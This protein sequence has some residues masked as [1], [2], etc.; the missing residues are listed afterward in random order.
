MIWCPH[1]R[2]LQ[3]RKWPGYVSIWFSHQFP[4]HDFLYFQFMIFCIFYYS[5]TRIFNSV[6]T[7]CCKGICD[8]LCP[9]LQSMLLVRSTFNGNL[10]KNMLVGIRFLWE[11]HSLYFILFSCWRNC[12][13]GK[14]QW[15]LVITLSPFFHLFLFVIFP[16]YSS[17]EASKSCILWYYDR[18]ITQEVSLYIF[19]ILSRVLWWIII[20]K[21]VQLKDGK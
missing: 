17:I 19:V 21:V 9:L 7:R 14:N 20:S 10:K 15:V 4:V 12:W 8:I 5:A 16:A 6:M 3:T 11:L 2:S 1:V 13:T 18:R